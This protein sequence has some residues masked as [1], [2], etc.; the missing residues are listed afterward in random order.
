MYVYRCPRNPSH[1]VVVRDKLTPAPGCL[2]HLT[3]EDEPVTMALMEELG[4]VLLPLDQEP[5]HL[6][7]PGMVPLKVKHLKDAGILLPETQHALEWLYRHRATNGMAPAFLK[8]GGRR[9][10][11]LVAFAKLMRETKA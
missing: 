6:V 5:A 9:C 10:I 3:A 4:K 1:A 2:Q 8:V 11:D 7:T